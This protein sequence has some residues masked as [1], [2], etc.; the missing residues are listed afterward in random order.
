MILMADVNQRFSRKATLITSMACF[1]D[2]TLAKV[3]MF[4]LLAG[5][6]KSTAFMRS[7]ISPL[8]EFEIELKFFSESG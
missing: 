3:V 1:V 4:R 8:K 7:N 6:G 5:S 2:L